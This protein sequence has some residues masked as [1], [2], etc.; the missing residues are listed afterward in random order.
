MKDQA[1]WNNALPEYTN[2][3]SVGLTKLPLGF[4]CSVSNYTPNKQFVFYYGIIH[5]IV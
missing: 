3:E 5:T 2:Q 1:I 4:P